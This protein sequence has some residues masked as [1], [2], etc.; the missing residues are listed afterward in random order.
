MD[1]SLAFFESFP[2][3]AVRA[4]VI[5]FTT[6]MITLAARNARR[7]AS[8]TGTA[9][10]KQAQLL[11][12]FGRYVDPAVARGVLSRGGAAET[13]E[14]TVLFTDL[15]NFTSLSEKMSPEATLEVLNAHYRAIVPAVHQH[16]GTVNKFIGDAI[17]ATFGAPLAQDDHALRAVRA[18]EAMLAAMDEL[19]ARFRAAGQPQLEMGIGIATGQVV[20]GSLGDPSRVEYAIIGDTVNTASRL[21]AMNKELSTRL[22]MS[23][24]T[25]EAAGNALQAQARSL[26]EIALRGKAHPVAVYTL[27][28]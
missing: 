18:A 22:L 19:N 4:V 15:R 5:A 23:A 25:R 12:L 20:V 8:T 1:P 14:V 16:G 10:G 26:G 24:A 13:R 17:M 7:M 2:M 6:G 28:A 3:W 21:E 27:A 9:M 11:Q